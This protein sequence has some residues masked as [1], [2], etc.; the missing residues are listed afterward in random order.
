ME[1]RPNVSLVAG[2]LYRATSDKLGL[3][4]ALVELREMAER[5]EIRKPVF[6]WQK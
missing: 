1:K 6:F 5:D 3:R 4:V 2:A